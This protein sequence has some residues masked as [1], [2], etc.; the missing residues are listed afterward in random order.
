MPSYI[1]TVLFFFFMALADASHQKTRK[2]A[3]QY[4]NPG[5]CALILWIV[6]QVR[7]PGA[8][9]SAGYRVL[10]VLG[11]ETVSNMDVTGKFGLVLIILLSRGSWSAWKHPKR[12]AFYRVPI[13][14]AADA[15]WK[16]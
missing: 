1:L 5:A 13:Y 12:L 2:I 6:I 15:K 8:K 9:E 4:C 7:L 10:W 3:L 11:V 14:V 16:S